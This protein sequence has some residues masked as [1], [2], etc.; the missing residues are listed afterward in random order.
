MP[1]QQ[2]HATSR[3]GLR[4]AEAWA[5]IC[6]LHHEHLPVECLVQ[7]IKLKKTMDLCMSLGRSCEIAPPSQESGTVDTAGARA[8]LKPRDSGSSKR[9]C[10]TSSSSSSFS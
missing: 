3:A 10:K 4:P 7:G 2:L 8:W 5:N 9:R 1:H 6:E